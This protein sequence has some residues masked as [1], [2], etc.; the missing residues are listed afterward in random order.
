[1]KPR[2][3]FAVVW[4]FCFWSTDKTSNLCVEKH[5][6]VQEVTDS[7]DR[8]CSSRSN[9]GAYCFFNNS[10]WGKRRI[11]VSSWPFKH[12]KIALPFQL[13][14]VFFMSLFGSFCVSW[15]LIIIN[16]QV[17]RNW[18]NNRVNTWTPKK[19]PTED[20]ERIFILITLKVQ[21]T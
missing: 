6:I 20:G 13:Y 11:Q 16:Q 3:V 4:R 9:G 7:S 12:Q 21:R 18:C 19:N 10:V 8:T 1:M 17:K 2:I 5:V 15:F 14:I